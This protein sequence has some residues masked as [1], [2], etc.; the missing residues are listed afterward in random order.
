MKKYYTTP[1][2]VVSPVAY[3]CMLTTDSVGLDDDFC[4]KESGNLILEDDDWG[5]N[6]AYD[7]WGDSEE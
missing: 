5:N 6:V 3:E 4:A 1:E 2:T 7:L